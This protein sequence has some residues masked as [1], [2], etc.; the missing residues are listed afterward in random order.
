MADKYTLTPQ[1]EEVYTDP[2]KILKIIDWLKGKRR[3]PKGYPGGELGLGKTYLRKK[4]DRLDEI[5]KFTFNKSERFQTKTDYD[6]R[7]NAYAEKKFQELLDRQ[8]ISWIREEY[9]LNK[10]K[11]IQRYL[12]DFDRSSLLKGKRM[13]GGGIASLNYLTRPIG[14]R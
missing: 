9:E 14:Y 2:G 8:D 1:L 7:R 10:D 6:R 11:Y 13:A 3:W 12:G 4:E 5:E